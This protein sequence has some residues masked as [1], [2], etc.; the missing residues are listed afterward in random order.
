MW[1]SSGL[2][3]SMARGDYG[4]QLPITINGATFNE[5]DEFKFRISQ[6]GI[7][8]VEKTFTSIAENTIDLTLTEE[9][10]NKLP[11]GTYVYALDWYQNGVFMC[12][13]VPMS[14]FKVV[15]KA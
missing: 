14:I 5:N 2:N 3:L 8:L 1:N 7:K 4:V 12:N 13:V 6:N 10:A 15:E 11:V 9:E